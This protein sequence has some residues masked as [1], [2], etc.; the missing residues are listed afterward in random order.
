MDLGKREFMLRKISWGIPSRGGQKNEGTGIGGCIS[1]I[2][3]T[4]ASVFDLNENIVRV[5]DLWDRSVFEPDSMD[6]LK[7]EGEILR[8]H[9]SILARGYVS[10]SAPRKNFYHTFGVSVL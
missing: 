1:Y 9:Q 4:D 2:A 5:L 3:T 10:F 8:A 6:A 7:D